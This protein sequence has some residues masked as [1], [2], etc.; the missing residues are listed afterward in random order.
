[1]NERTL[2]QDNVNYRH[3]YQTY[4]KYMQRLPAQK[5]WVREKLAAHLK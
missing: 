1:M 5:K 3:T 4:D 2:L